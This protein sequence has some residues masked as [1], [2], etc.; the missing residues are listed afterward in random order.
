MNVQANEGWADRLGMSARIA[1]IVIVAI[2]GLFAVGVVVGL[3]VA[4]IEDGARTKLTVYV[5]LAL[6]IGLSAVCGWLLAKLVRSMR[7]A[8]MSS[9]DRRY[10][11]MWVVIAAIGVPLGIGLAAIADD[12]PGDSKWLVLSNA[13]LAP[14]TA[15]LASVLLV[16][17]L[18]FAAIYYHRTVD[19]HEERAYLW[20]S[21]IAYYFLLFAF[22]LYWLLARGGLV[23]ILGIGI[24]L[25]IILI[26]C[27]LQAIV[28]CLF[29]FR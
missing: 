13:P 17:M 23:P 25:L 1:L 3:T 19:D 26:S 11:K 27:I 28:F 9:F 4:L 15:I 5:I 18:A 20:G 8:S 7:P 6:S 16:V 22:P 14:M 2:L 24:A 12:G 29:K 21:T 10:W